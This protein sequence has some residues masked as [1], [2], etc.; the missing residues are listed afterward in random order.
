MQKKSRLEPDFERIEH[1][2]PKM[3]RFP[4]MG[5]FVALSYLL[6]PRYFCSWTCSTISLPI[7][8]CDMPRSVTVGEAFGFLVSDTEGVSHGTVGS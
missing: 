6:V 4:I 8:I 7:M 3:V 2:G 5:P 1:L